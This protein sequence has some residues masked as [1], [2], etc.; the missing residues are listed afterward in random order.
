MDKYLERLEAGWALIGCENVE[1]L[2][3]GLSNEPMSNSL[4]KALDVSIKGNGKNN[5]GT[6]VF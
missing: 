2:V 1:G 6:S 4:G 3:K 5:L